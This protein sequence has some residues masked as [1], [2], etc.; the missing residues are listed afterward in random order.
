MPQYHLYSADISPFGQRV[1][2]LMKFKNL[3]YTRESPPGG[4]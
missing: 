3:N 4:L 2:M 1:E